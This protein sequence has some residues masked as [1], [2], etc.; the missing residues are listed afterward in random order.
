MIAGVSDATLYRWLNEAGF[1]SAWDDP[2]GWIQGKVK[3]NRVLAELTSMQTLIAVQNDPKASTRDRV[4]AAGKALTHTQRAKE[5]EDAP[6]VAALSELLRG[7]VQ[8]GMREY[9]P[10]V[11][12]ALRGEALAMVS[13]D[14]A[15]DRTGTALLDMP[16]SEAGDDV[17]SV[18]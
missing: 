1:R 16:R 17:V 13:D 15:V 18:P 6:K 11:E 3:S 14:G 2:K 5:H 10:A 12:Q 4:D 9:A 7:Y 8:E